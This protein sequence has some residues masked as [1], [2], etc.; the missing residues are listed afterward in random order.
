MPVKK[1][2]KSP[3][4]KLLALYTFFMVQGESYTSLTELARILE[5]SKQT[6]SRLLL[7]LEASGYGKLDTP[8]VKGKE[9]YH[10]FAPMPMLDLNLGVKELMQLNLCR[11]LFLQM[12]PKGMNAFLGDAP[13]QTA[14][15][16]ESPLLSPFAAAAKNFHKGYIDYASYEKQYSILLQ[17]TQKQKVCMVTYKRSPSKPARTF[18]F[19]P[20]RLISF[21]ESL[22]FHGWEVDEAHPA[23]PKYDNALSLYLQRCQEVQMT[24]LDA[25]HISEPPYAQESTKV[26]PFGIMQGDS[27]RVRIL[28]AAETA[29]YIYDRVWSNRQSMTVQD[30]G[31]LMLDFDAQSPPEIVSWVFSFGA[32]A[33]V[34]EPHWLRDELKKQ[35]TMLAQ[36]Y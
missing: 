34:L 6:V 33:K 11:N 28:F 36:S 7:Q 20:K 10:R 24:E 15:K 29:A 1:S 26:G 23:Q 5:C 3:G 35:V 2:E 32:K 9:H 18:A 25:S 30:D 16:P 21:R 4:E 27:F 13:S 8:L 14:E 17:A 31:S 12:L 19:A 22:S